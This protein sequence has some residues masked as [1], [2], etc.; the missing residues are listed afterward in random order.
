[1]LVIKPSAGASFMLHKNRSRTTLFTF[2]KGSVLPEKVVKIYDI[3]RRAEIDRMCDLF[4]DITCS[5]DSL[6]R[7]SVP[8]LD[9]RQVV[10]GYYVVQEEFVDGRLMEK[11]AQSCSPAWGRRFGLNCGLVRLWLECFNRHFSYK[12]IFVTPETAAFA[13]EGV[14]RFIEPARRL[15][16]D[17]PDEPIQLPGVI[18]HLDLR[19]S[20]VVRKK[21]W[22]VI[23]DWDYVKAGGLPLFDLLE[24]IF[25][26]LHAHYKFQ[27][28][29]IHLAPKT[30][31][32]Y[33][34]LMFGKRSGVS[35]VV[36]ENIGRYCESMELGEKERRRLLMM[37]KYSMLYN[38][39]FVVD[40]QRHAVLS[41]TPVR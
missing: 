12:P 25:R 14:E 23:L 35:R 27:K 24:F 29:G 5:K 34:D 30:F 19:P 2:R 33:A 28:T 41:D 37:W 17:S 26:Y 31:L 3:S 6:V 21:G 16:L 4:R 1:M 40:D 32:R 39:K 13:R 10:D 20:N 7:Q 36:D 9:F 22:A 8:R 18:S 38:R 15:Y 11:D